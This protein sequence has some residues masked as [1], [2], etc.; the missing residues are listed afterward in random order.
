MYSLSL[1]DGEIFLQTRDDPSLLVG[2]P[3]RKEGFGGRGSSIRSA[4]R[5]FFRSSIRRSVPWDRSRRRCIRGGEQGRGQSRFIH[6]HVGTSVLFWCVVIGL[7]PMDSWSFRQDGDKYGDYLG[8]ITSRVSGDAAPRRDLI[9]DCDSTTSMGNYLR[10]VAGA[11]GGD[12]GTRRR[13]KWPKAAVVAAVACTRQ[14]GI[15]DKVFI[16]GDTRDCRDVTNLLN[17]LAADVWSRCYMPETDGMYSEFSVC[18]ALEARPRV[19]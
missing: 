7:Y 1:V 19:V 17:S 4:S 13:R 2:S 3:L 14:V 6:A 8:R 10:L 18:R 5:S 15:T 12:R 9:F 11:G 16:L